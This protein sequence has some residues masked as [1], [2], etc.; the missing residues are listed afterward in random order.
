MA[1]DILTEVRDGVYYVTLNRPQ[2]KNAVRP[3]HLK[4]IGEA[5]EAA[6]EMDD[7][8]CVVLG[9][10]PGCF[11]AG[12]ELTAQAASEQDPE[13]KGKPTEY[14][15]KFGYHRAFHAIWE[16]E[17]PVVAAMDGPA[18]GVGGGLALVC[19]LRLGSPRA[20][21]G[22][23]F[24]KIGLM[25]DGGGTFFLPRLVGFAKT[26]E[27]VYTGEIVDAEEMLRLGLLNKLYG[28]DEFPERVHAFARAIAE[29]PPVAFKYAKRAMRENL[30]ADMKQALD[31]EAEYQDICIQTPD[32]FEGVAA[33]F[34]KRAPKFTGEPGPAGG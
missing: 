23:V 19:D 14:K 24:R 29:G 31:R 25:P 27:L 26:Y 34:E 10:A 30:F 2:V 16:L 12:A 6:R 3:E 1:D 22:E 9:G 32:F 28:L 33:R 21:Y 4:R 11:C 13:F 17:K 7:V 15:L 8:R 5:V 20:R 18:V